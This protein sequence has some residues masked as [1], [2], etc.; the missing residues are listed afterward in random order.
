MYFFYNI[1]YLHNWMKI[2]KVTY[3]RA[4]CWLKIKKPNAHKAYEIAKE[5]ERQLEEK[6]ACDIQMIK[7]KAIAANKRILIK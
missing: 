6:K 3:T 1:A 4:N 5:R 7:R 2:C